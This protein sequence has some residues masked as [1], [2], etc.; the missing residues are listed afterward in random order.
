MNST[1]VDVLPVPGLRRGYQYW[2]R[3]KELLGIIAN[4]SVHQLIELERVDLS[5]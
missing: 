4:V 5:F 1:I 2:I 3:S